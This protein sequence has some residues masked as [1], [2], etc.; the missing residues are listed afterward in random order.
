MWDIVLCKA[1]VA[2][3]AGKICNV[4]MADQCSFIERQRNTP[5]TWAAEGAEES[6]SDKCLEQWGKERSTMDLQYA[7]RNAQNLERN[8]RF[9]VLHSVS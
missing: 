7:A 8:A 4:P 6:L 9:E 2:G 5:L 1:T 3:R